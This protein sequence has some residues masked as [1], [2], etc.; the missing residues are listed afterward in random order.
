VGGNSQQNI[1]VLLNQ[2]GGNFSTAI[3]SPAGGGP[4]T[5]KLGDFNGD[6]VLDI[7]AGN[8]GPTVNVFIGDGTGSFAAPV[9]FVA[10]PLPFSVTTGDFNRDGVLDF[11]SSDFANGTT[12]V[13]IG[14]TTTSTALTFDFS[15]AS[16]AGAR[17]AIPMLQNKLDHL[18]SQRGRI[19]AYASRLTTAS[20][21][22]QATAENYDSASSKITDVD[23]AEES[24]RLAATQILQQSAS[25]I[26]AQAN[27]QPTLALSLLRTI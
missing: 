25:S 27:Q 20:N 13:Y 21:V 8:A 16:L 2:G 11:A 1:G 15:L 23:V 5:P 26:L 17:E 12:S 10:E 4:R 19:G 22:L 6:G 14:E 9:S 7:I 24:S 3:I 18:T